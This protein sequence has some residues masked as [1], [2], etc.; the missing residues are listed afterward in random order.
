M[1]YNS[2]TVEEAPYISE[3]LK[4]TIGS[5][6]YLRLHRVELEVEAIELK[7]VVLLASRPAIVHR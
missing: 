4:P 2:D 7:I 3:P 5:P 1:S 6:L